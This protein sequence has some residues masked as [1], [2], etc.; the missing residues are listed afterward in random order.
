MKVRAKW[1]C[2]AAEGKKGYPS[3][4]RCLGAPEPELE[5]LRA[6]SDSGGGAS[7]NRGSSG[8]VIVAV[9]EES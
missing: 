9:K 3:D 2:G 5:V 1:D 4:R 6:S 8:S 7:G